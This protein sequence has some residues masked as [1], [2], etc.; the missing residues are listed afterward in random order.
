VSRQPASILTFA[1]FRSLIAMIRGK[2]TTIRDAFRSKLPDS[3]GP[4]LDPHLLDPDAEIDRT[5]AILDAMSPADQS[6]LT[7]ID[8]EGRRRVAEGAGVGLSHVA[9]VLDLYGE[10]LRAVERELRGEAPSQQMPPTS[11]LHSIDA[12][13]LHPSE[14]GEFR[15]LWDAMTRFGWLPQGAGPWLSTW[16]RGLRLWDFDLK[17]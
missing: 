15:E 2:G 17:D 3:Y 7:A 14:P 13:R 1:Y 6:D 8:A 9:A 16:N 12:S 5:L 4:V 11:H 10:L